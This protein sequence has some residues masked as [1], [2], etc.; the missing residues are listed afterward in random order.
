[1]DY[2]IVGTVSAA[3]TLKDLLNSPEKLQVCDLVELRFDEHMNSEECLDLCK[4]L[5]EHTKVLLTIRTNREGGTWDIEDE[6]RFKLFQFFA[7]DVDMIDLEL[8]SELFKNHSRSEFP[9]KLTVISSFHDY[10]KTPSGDEIQKLIDSGKSWGADIVKLAV[11]SST[12]QDIDLLESFLKQGGLCLIAMGDLGSV[13]RSKFPLK[14][15]LLTYG[16]LDE[17]AAPG[18]FSAEELNKLLR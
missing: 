12:E 7:N 1:M 11:T 4:Q 10:E 17:S 18:Q 9:E 16:Y 8:K 15:S 3:A 5:R 13:T 14:G 6:K 2:Q